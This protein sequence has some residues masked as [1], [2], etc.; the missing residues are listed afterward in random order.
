[1]PGDKLATAKPTVQEGAVHEAGAK[2]EDDAEMQAT[3]ARRLNRDFSEE[4]LEVLDTWDNAADYAD[5]LDLNRQFL[6]GELGFTCYHMGPIYSE[7]QPMVPGLLRLHDFGILTLESQP[8]KTVGPTYEEC[9]CCEDT[10]WQRTQHRAFITFLLPRSED[11]VSVAELERFLIELM[12]DD[13]LY[14]SMLSSE[15]RCRRRG[16]L[17]KPQSATSFPKKWFTHQVKKVRRTF[18]LCV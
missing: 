16:C 1:M 3:V 12:V 14:V 5:L 11:W 9:K 7:T 6:R 8:S 4:D 10:Y 13:R 17:R 2:V 18:L 15:G